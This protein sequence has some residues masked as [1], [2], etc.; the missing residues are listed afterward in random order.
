V[1]MFYNVLPDDGPAID[2][3]PSAYVALDRLIAEPAL[4]RQVVHA[5]LALANSWAQR[6]GHYKELRKIAAAI[7]ETIRSFKK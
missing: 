6:Y 3:R 7:T 5:A 4:N 2:G 1:R